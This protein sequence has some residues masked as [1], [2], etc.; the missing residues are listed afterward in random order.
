MAED[1]GMMMQLI[2][3]VNAT[4]SSGSN[5]VRRATPAWCRWRM[6]G[7]FVPA[8]N[9]RFAMIVAARQIGRDDA[10]RRVAR[11]PRRHRQHSVRLAQAAAQKLPDGHCGVLQRGEGKS[12]LAL[13]PIRSGSRCHLHGRLSRGRHSSP[14]LSEK[15]IQTLAAETTTSDT[16]QA[17]E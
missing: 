3:I 7:Q 13:A 8:A 14:A 4:T 17:A 2:H 10:A 12:M 11:V 9:A 16:S 5:R 1:G 15:S 6:A